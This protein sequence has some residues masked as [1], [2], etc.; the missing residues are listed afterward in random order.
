MGQ[1]M[2]V[3][4]KNGSV[5][6]ADPQ[7]RGQTPS[8]KQAVSL[9]GI[10]EWTMPNLALTKRVPQKANASWV[11]KLEGAISQRLEVLPAQL[12]FRL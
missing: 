5:R 12:N 3:N 10:E 8:T 9:Q 4:S 11:L 1:E 6:G 2:Q 7:P